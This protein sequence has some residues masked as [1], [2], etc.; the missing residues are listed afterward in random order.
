MN[1]NDDEV[2]IP[3][4]VDTDQARANINGLREDAQALDDTLLE[5]RQRGTEVF[6]QAPEGKQRPARSYD[7]VEQR[8]SQYAPD[9]YAQQNP[10][11]A[12]IQAGI[13]A[14]QDAIDA[15]LRDFVQAHPDAATLS[16]G[17][18]YQA[19]GAWSE[20]AP[21]TPPPP[22]TATP[23]P[24]T[25]TPPAVG[26]AWPATFTQPATAPPSPP[27]IGG[28]SP[29]P[30]SPTSGLAPEALTRLRGDAES[31]DPDL[32]KRETQATRL[33]NALK[34]PGPSDLSNSSRKPLKADDYDDVRAQLATRTPE[35]VWALSPALHQAVMGAEDRRAT[36]GGYVDQFAQATTAPAPESVPTG[37]QPAPLAQP[38]QPAPLVQ[39]VQPVQPA[40]LVQSVQSAQPAQPAQPAPGA[41]G[42]QSSA[43]ADVY[44]TFSAWLTQQQQASS[45]TTQAQ[46]RAS[47]TTAGG[48]LSPSIFGG[49]GSG[50]A[51]DTD[52]TA[53]TFADKISSAL[54]HS[55][56]SVAAGLTR[57]TFDAAG[58]GAAG[59]VISGIARPV[60]GAL[61][62]LFAPVAGAFA[63]VGV[64]L[65][66]NDQSTRL[67]REQR[68]M[69]ASIG[70]TSGA[71]PAQELA[72]IQHTG[73]DYF[74]SEKQS[75]AAAKQMG[76]AGLDSTQVP[77]ALSNA[78][79]FSTMTGM[80][81]GQATSLS[82]TMM[83]QGGLSVD[84]VAQA[85]Q[86]MA[87][88]AK[89]SG[90]SV[91]RITESMKSFQQAGGSMAL[92]VNGLAAAAHE[93]G[94][95]IDTGRLLGPIASATGGQAIQAM[96]LTGLTPAQF[97]AM[98]GDATHAGNPA[99]MWDAIAGVA[100]RYD[101]GTYGTQV[102]E[103]I[104]GQS[105]LVDFT[106]MSA[107]QQNTLVQKLVAQGPKAAEDYAA[108]LNKK[109]S[110]PKSTDDWHT[111]QQRASQA[112]TSAT[113][114]AK[115]HVEQLGVAAAGAA[116]R[117]GGLDN[118]PA[119]GDPR[120]Q[121]DGVDR[122]AGAN[123]QRIQPTHPLQGDTT[124][125]LAP[126]LPPGLPPI[127]PSTTQATPHGYDP[128]A[129]GLAAAE[130]QGLHVQ[131][132]HG[133]TLYA[134]P[135]IVRAIAQAAHSKGVD[136]AMMIAQAAQESNLNPTARSADG[137]VGLFQFTDPKVA[138][139]YS[140]QATNELHMGDMD[141]KQAALNPR[142][143]A[144]M[145]ADYDKDLLHGG[146][147][148]RGTH[149][150]ITHALAQYN[151]GPNGWNVLKPGEGRWYGEGVAGN[152]AAVRGEI[153][154]TVHV[155]DAD[156]K[157]NVTHTQTSHSVTMAPVHHNINPARKPIA[158]QSYGPTDHTPPAPGIPILPGHLR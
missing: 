36:I 87:K 126:A 30:A 95:G 147:G 77:G 130:R 63:A 46:G 4:T 19:Y 86:R 14:R 45:A 144:Q 71:Q 112:Y 133:D 44:R 140:Q 94:P 38:V 50:T 8:T 72:A 5:L 128:Q 89:A 106:G 60:A 17:A 127:R 83:T 152:A 80:D 131:N 92:N 114:Q 135:S 15:R 102:T 68:D 79:A 116:L 109:E 81:R 158:H 25:P 39:P 29:S 41:Q 150:D 149:G 12:R 62:E 85:M 52:R 120:Y 97:T 74:V 105:G 28:A 53:T 96:A 3:L 117:L 65:G 143:A 142:V 138:Q 58:M 32:Q 2:S 123:P 35:D 54:T 141:W 121:H 155:K 88:A 34:M 33:F 124:V 136:P 154:V 9:L 42:A 27:A 55:G 153:T 26:A 98:Q 93:A 82:T 73:W 20:T 31:L 22:S 56:G 18:F 137:G 67:L 113:D 100:K 75:V 99:Q 151:A 1:E 132:I 129:T 110:T 108:S 103:Q 125:G 51:Q 156:T 78:L 148:Q 76:D 84:Q 11:M 157:K 47:S 118:G 69:G 104:L 146:H 57:G 90:V 61:G 66:V 24:G 10:E 40:P 13:A 37:V 91:D 122:S 48:T 64:G 6:N 49:S 101:R 107:A 111:S 16:G 134:Q 43:P 119:K 21:P 23:A 115:I 59:D 139:Q 145:A 70:T 7:E